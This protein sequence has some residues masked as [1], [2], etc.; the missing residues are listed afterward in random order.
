[1]RTFQPDIDELS[2][3]IMSSCTQL[4]AHRSPFLLAFAQRKQC[5]LLFI[6]IGFDENPRPFPYTFSY[7]EVCTLKTQ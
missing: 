5:N 6:G 1:M 3:I 4:D 7:Y 2:S